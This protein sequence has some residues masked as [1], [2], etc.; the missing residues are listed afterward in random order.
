MVEHG[1]E[2]T[3]AGRLEHGAGGGV[4]VR[5]GV[6]FMSLLTAARKLARV[7][8]AMRSSG[9]KL[10]S[11]RSRLHRVSRRWARD[12][13]P[14]Q[15]L[16]HRPELTASIA[17]RPVC[18]YSIIDDMQRL[19]PPMLHPRPEVPPLTAGE[20]AQRA[21]AIAFAKFPPST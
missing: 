20:V 2:A 9:S 12:R 11:R 1:S 19:T 17:H 16:R 5:L 10:N 14:R 4:A 7:S 21:P 18:S 15:R 13:G 6:A 8:C 3:V